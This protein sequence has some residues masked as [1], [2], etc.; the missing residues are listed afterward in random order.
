MWQA[1]W[2]E[3]D[4]RQMAKLAKAGWSAA[5]IAVR[6]QTTRN[7]IIGRMSRVNAPM[8]LVVRSQ[9]KT[10]EKETKIRD[11]PVNLSRYDT[12]GLLGDSLF[13]G[14]GVSLLVA[15][16]HHCRWPLDRRGK[17]GIPQC[18][19]E[20]SVVPM[21]YCVQHHRL[22]FITRPKKEAVSA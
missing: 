4:D 11:R 1:R 12:R 3:K 2:T 9:P 21:G 13:A 20:E 18:C 17:D 19:G 14:Q 8:R 5:K 16:D 15:R 7:A 10:V 6:F 22:S